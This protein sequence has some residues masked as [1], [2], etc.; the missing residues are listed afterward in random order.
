MS[1][2]K[3]PFEAPS[4]AK[5]RKT[6]DRVEKERLHIYLSTLCI[7]RVDE[8]AKDLGLER[9]QCIQT[10]L[11]YALNSLQAIHEPL[12]PPPSVLD[13]IPTS[14]LQRKAKYSPAV[15]KKKNK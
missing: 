14:P 4:V 5:K 12:K 3:E 1:E 8:K 7:G 11:N 6:R 9:S 2:P 15:K 13:G 10:L